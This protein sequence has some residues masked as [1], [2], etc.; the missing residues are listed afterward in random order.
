MTSHWTDSQRAAFWAAHRRGD[1]LLYCL[2]DVDG[3]PCNGGG[4]NDLPPAAPG[5]VHTTTSRSICSHGLHATSEPHRWLGQVVWIVALGPDAETDGDD[6]W[7]STRREII[8]MIRPEEAV[9]HWGVALRAGRNDLRW[10]DLSRADLSEA[11]L[12]GASL[13]GA[14]LRGANLREANLTGASLA[15]ADLSR[16]YLTR[17]NLAGANLAGADL[18]WADLSRADLREANLTGASL[19]G[20]DLTGADLTGAD[21]SRA[22]LTRA[23]LAG[24][25]LRW[26]DLRWANLR[27]ADLSRADLREANL[28]GANLRYHGWSIGS[29]GRAVRTPV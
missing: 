21:L 6:K 3:R 22:Y 24:A 29:D 20:A 13:G 2:T 28:T 12:T 19:G 26:A 7:C 4:K 17:A 11:N 9:F 14:N 15:G 1:K 10:A 23:N 8:G 27:A 18:R 25:D 16:D 5:V